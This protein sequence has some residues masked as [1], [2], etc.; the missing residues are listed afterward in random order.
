MADMIRIGAVW[1][2]SGQT[3]LRMGMDS[4]LAR[5]IRDFGAARQHHAYLFANASGTR[6]KV[7]VYDGAGLWLCSRRLQSGRFEWGQGQMQQGISLEQLEWLVQGLPWSKRH[8]PMA[9]AVV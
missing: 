4:L 9:I 8:P 1:L 7:L 6:L 3:D 5:V 2:C